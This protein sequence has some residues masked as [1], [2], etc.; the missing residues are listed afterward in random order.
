[1]MYNTWEE[2]AENVSDFSIMTNS[3]ANNGNPFGAADYAKTEIE[4]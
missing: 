3:V 1:M 4:S 2:I